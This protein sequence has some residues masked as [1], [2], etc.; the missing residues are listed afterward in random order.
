MQ[1]VFLLLIGF[2][3]LWTLQLF[4]FHAFIEVCEHVLV[5]FSFVSDG[6]L[7]FLLETDEAEKVELLGFFDGLDKAETIQMVPLVA[8]I[9][10]FLVSLYISSSPLPGIYFDRCNIM[11]NLQ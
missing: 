5:L 10:F 1:G 2:S 3:G 4:H 8:F 9:A 7:I 6:V 11:I